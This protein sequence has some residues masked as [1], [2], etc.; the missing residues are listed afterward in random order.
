MI[1]TT[2]TYMAPEECVPILLDRTRSPVVAIDTEFDGSRPPSQADLHGVSIAGGTPETGL[3]GTYW[4]FGGDGDTW[5]WAMLR[6]RVLRPLYADAERVITMHPPKVD[7]QPLRRRGVGGPDARARI[8]CTMSQAHVYDENLPKG[9]KELAYALL[10]VS[11]VASYKDVQAEMKGLLKEG[12]TLVKQILAAGWE[13]YKTARKVS[14]KSDPIP[15]VVEDPSWP[16][17]HKLVMRLPA[18]GVKKGEVQDYLRERVEP[19]VMAD[20]RQRA[21]RRFELYGTEDALYTLGV[22]YYL[23]RAMTPAQRVTAD[24]E[25]AVCH[26]IVTE[27]E[28]VG[29]MVDVDRLRVIHQ[30]LEEAAAEL[31]AQVVPAWQPYFVQAG[32]EGEFN[33]GSHDQLAKIIW[34][35]W[36][37]R[38]PKWAQQGGE[39][40]NKW[41]RA[42]DGLCKTDKK[43]MAWLLGEHGVTNTTR[44]SQ[45]QALV[46]LHKLEDMIADRSR[47]LLQLVEADPQHRV[48]SSFWP[49]K[50][51]TGRFASSDPNVENI[52]RP[53]SMPYVRVSPGADP[54]K[55]PSGLV[56]VKKPDGHI[57]TSR[58][59]VASLRDCFVAEPGWVLVSADLSQ[60]E[61]RLVAFESQDPTLLQVFRR[62]D[63]AACGQHGETDQP[64]KRCPACG[65]GPGG[66]DKTHPEQPAQYA[67]RCSNGHKGKAP[68]RVDFCTECGSREVQGG[69]F[70]LGKDIHAH[71]SASLGWHETKGYAKGRQDAKAVNHAT[72]Y[73]MG[74]DTMSQNYGMD[75]KECQAALEAWHARHPNVEGVLHRKVERSIRERGLVEMFDGEHVRRFDAFKLLL[76]AGCLEQWEWDK[77]VR[78]GVN[79]TAQ[80]GTGIIVK[81]AM[82]GIRQEL[83]D[84]RELRKV[85]CVNQ[86]H[87]EVLYEAPEEVAD[88]AL[89]VLI[90]HLE[91]NR[92]TRMLNVPIIAEGGKGRTWGAAH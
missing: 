68:A 84:T 88:Q 85:R 87:D 86:V 16:S 59:Q 77:I 39:I 19:V 37:Q 32:F 65:S 8:R 49:V 11:G 47:P 80:G 5:P 57:D 26:P 48:H 61:N 78:E 46:E 17:W 1:H 60:I 89:A 81:E 35:V 9:L 50:P 73:G 43:V 58:W 74:A 13:V 3:V 31:R 14:R 44:R 56:L 30:R 64:L 6:D 62:W 42:K 25:A 72:A 63:C 51:R 27:M 23:Q 12:E 22:D 21:R 38:P 54:H 83:L 52:P 18:R 29:I 53:G 79:A 45:L 76:D 70:C 55:P 67:W 82:Q 71:T 15:E 66:R 24:W 7:A 69:G 40:K 41:R 36:G 92:L 10:G 20:Y 4:H 91:D 75:K 2:Y 33:P 90:R 34:E 28:E